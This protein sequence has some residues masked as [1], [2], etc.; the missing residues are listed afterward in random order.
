MNNMWFLKLVYEILDLHGA[1]KS[2]TYL[3]LCIASNIK[4]CS[5]IHMKIGYDEIIQRIMKQLG[6][7]N[8]PDDKTITRKSMR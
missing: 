2:I 6:K 8:I 4:Y 7:R 1:F 3:F 5:V